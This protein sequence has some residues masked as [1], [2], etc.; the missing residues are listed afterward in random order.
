MK[1]PLDPKLFCALIAL[2]A[3][4]GCTTTPAPVT[5]HPQDQQQST[6]PVFAFAAQVSSPTGE[7][8]E[9]GIPSR[10]ARV[11][12]Y[13]DRALV[14]REAAVTLAGE[15]TVFR[16]KKLP[17]WVDEGSVRAATSAGKILDV[18]VER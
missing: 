7:P 6:P 1:T 4:C 18:T 2:S 17:G 15:P 9:K 12:V 13:S 14:S 8:E 3:A 10:I 11:T 16:F 5:P